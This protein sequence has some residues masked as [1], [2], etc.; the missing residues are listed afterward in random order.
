MRAVK[1]SLAA[2]LMAKWENRK[3]LARAMACLGV[4]VGGR[5][6]S[7]AFLSTLLG[8]HLLSQTCATGATSGKGG[9]CEMGG[10]DDRH[11]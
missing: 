7:Q 6:R 10:D 3:T 9:A 11:E 2:P 8:V 1:D 5:V 4:P